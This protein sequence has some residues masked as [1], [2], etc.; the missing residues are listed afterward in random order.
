MIKSELIRELAESI[1]KFGDSE[2]F[3]DI[4]GNKDYV[5]LKITEIVNIIEDFEDRVYISCDIEETYNPKN[6]LNKVKLI[7]DWKE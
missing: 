5:G 1:R 4:L 6:F 3:V 2:V 7:D